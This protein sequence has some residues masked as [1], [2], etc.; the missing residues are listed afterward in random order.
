MTKKKLIDAHLAYIV[1]RYGA[2]VMDQCK[3][4]HVEEV[5]EVLSVICPMGVEVVTKRMRHYGKDWCKHSV[6]RLE[7]GQLMADYV[8]NITK[9]R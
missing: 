9:K 5:N 8:E 7:T 1:D 2:K 6:Y 4:I 3:L